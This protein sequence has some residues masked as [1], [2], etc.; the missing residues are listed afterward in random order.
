MTSPHEAWIIETSKDGERWRFFGKA[1]VLPEERLLIHGLPRYVRVR[2]LEQ[3]EFGAVMPRTGPEPMAL[4]DLAGG[5]R[6]EIWPDLA[7]Y[8]LPVLLPGGEVGRL[9]KFEHTPDGEEWTWALE[10]RGSRADLPPGALGD[11]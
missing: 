7:H 8:G 6:S 3:P 4:I 2:R 1:W 11:A 10:F 9:Q 5:V